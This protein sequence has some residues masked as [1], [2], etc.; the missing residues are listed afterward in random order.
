MLAA[1]LLLLAACASPS[2]HSAPPSVA[3]L[4]GGVKCPTGDH[5]LS[6]RQL[7][8]SF[9]YPATWKFRERVQQSLAPVGVDDT[10]DIVDVP[11]APSPD[12]GKFGFVIIG[13]YV[14]GDSPDLAT[15]VKKY[16]GPDVQLERISWG[17]AKEAAIVSGS[18]RRYALTPNHVVMLDPRSGDGNLDVGGQLAK[19]LDTWS[20][21]F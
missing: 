14:R 8:W 19:R 3:P 9:C 11:P 20:F 7:G 10:F 6:E 15:W 21:S 5:G 12:Q 13:T 1:S 16:V 2:S 17:N 18:N 4:D